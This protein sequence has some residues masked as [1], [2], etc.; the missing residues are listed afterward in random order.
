M[1]DRMTTSW[2]RR[3]DKPRN[4]TDPG[5]SAQ[6]L[7]LYEKAG[8]QLDTREDEGGQSMLSNEPVRILIVDDDISSSDSLEL[9]LHAS[10][11]SETRVAY[12]GHAA[13][14]IAAEFQP[15]VALLELNLLDMSGYEVA[16]LLREH[17][18]SRD[19]RLIALTSSREHAGR[20]LARVAGFERYL[21]KP[22]ATLDLSGLL[23]MQGD[24]NE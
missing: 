11:Y 19:L 20:E 13:L 7:P 18:K 5:G 8:Q 16:R 17:A 14:A 15:S 12:S 9:M 6:M 2:R 24:G 21:L 3:S 1:Q 4:H 10:G 22:V 23:Q